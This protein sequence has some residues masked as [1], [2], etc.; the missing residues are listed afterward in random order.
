MGT[1]FAY[2]CYP[3][4]NIKKGFDIVL[5]LICEYFLRSGV[6]NVITPSSAPISWISKNCHRGE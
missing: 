4:M 6:D 3:M 1:G 5:F 2:K